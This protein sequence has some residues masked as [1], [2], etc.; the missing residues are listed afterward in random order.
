MRITTSAIFSFQQ[1]F[2]VKYVL[3]VHQNSLVEN[4]H[5]NP[6]T[7]SNT[8]NEKIFSWAPSER[9]CGYVSW[10]FNHVLTQALTAEHLFAAN[11]QYHWCGWQLLTYHTTKWIQHFI[12]NCSK[13]P[14]S[15]I[16]FDGLI[17]GKG[18]YFTFNFL[19]VICY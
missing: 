13:D 14:G 11:T 10:A 4:V 15:S 2:R 9:Q 12:S 18:F 1:N 6:S 7:L 8:V 5:I 17:V 3:S 16:P 19:Y